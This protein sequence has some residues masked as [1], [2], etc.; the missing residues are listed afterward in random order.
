MNQA[1]QTFE[2]KGEIAKNEDPF[3]DEAKPELLG[4][5]FYQ[6]EGL[7][8]LMDN[9]VEVPILSTNSTF[10]GKMVMNVVPCD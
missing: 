4:R 8:Y 7:A 2:E 5:A 3:V 6:L 10:V 1:I 9:P